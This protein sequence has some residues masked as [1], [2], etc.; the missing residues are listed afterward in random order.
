[1]GF[2][3]LLAWIVGMYALFTTLSR[4]DEDEEV[5]PRPA[6][7]RVPVASRAATRQTEAS[8]ELR[9]RSRVVAEEPRAASVRRSSRR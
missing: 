4:P 1:M 6:D 9:S 2:L 5:Q 7:R 3:L 8:R